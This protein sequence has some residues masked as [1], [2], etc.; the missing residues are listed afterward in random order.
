[1]SMKALRKDEMMKVM[2]GRGEQSSGSGSGQQDE[3]EDR[4]G[5]DQTQLGAV[6]PGKDLLP[7]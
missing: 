1:M 3:K 6:V 4:G 7:R 5:D 2:G